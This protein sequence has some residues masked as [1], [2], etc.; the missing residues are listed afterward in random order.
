L[1]AEERAALLAEA[2]I[3]DHAPDRPRVRRDVKRGEKRARGPAGPSAGPDS[4]APYVDFHPNDI[5]DGR[6]RS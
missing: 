3:A 4:P 2:L 5:K 6:A 1:T